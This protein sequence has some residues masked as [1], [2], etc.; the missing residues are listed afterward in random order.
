MTKM[1]IN[2]HT[3]AI[4]DD[5]AQLADHARALMAATADVA[6]EK[7]VEARKHLSAAL[8]SGKKGIGRIEDTAADGAKFIYKAVR[9]NPYQAIAIAIGVGALVACLASNRNCR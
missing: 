9:D 3:Q 1:T 6:G 8:E 4:T 2:K 7:V 5:M